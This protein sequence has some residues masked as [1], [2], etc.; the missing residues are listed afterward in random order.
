MR[1][2]K[3]GADDTVK[4]EEPPNQAGRSRRVR[5]RV[6]AAASQRSE[7]EAESSQLASLPSS[8]QDDAASS[9]SLTRALL[10]GLFDLGD[11]LTDERLVSSA[12]DDTAAWAEPQL[13]ASSGG[14]ERSLPSAAAAAAAAISTALRSSTV[15]VKLASH[16]HP[17]MAWTAAECAHAEQ[18][19]VLLPQLQ[20]PAALAHLFHITVAAIPRAEAWFAPQQ[21]GALAA[22]VR[23]GCTLITLHALL[24]AACEPLS[25]AELLDRVLATPGDGGAFLRAQDEVVVRAAG[26]GTEASYRRGAGL[27]GAAAKAVRAVD[28]APRL[29]PLAPLAVLCTAA[30][31]LALE[32]APSAG[33]VFHCRLATGRVLL[34]TFVA[35]DGGR[36]HVVLPRCNEAGVALLEAQPPGAPLHHLGAPRPVLLTSDAAIAAEVAAT[37]DALRVLHGTSDAMRTQVELAVTTLGAALSPSAT[38]AVQ[39]AAA[40]ASLIMGWRASLTCLLQSPA[41]TDD[42]A[43]AHARLLSLL[44]YA[45]ASTQ[46]NMMSVLM[47]AS[48]ML[49]RGGALAAALMREAL[50][51]GNTHSALAA[52]AALDTLNSRYSAEQLAEP[53]AAAAASLLRAIASAVDAEEA[54]V[55]YVSAFAKG[56]VATND[57]ASADFEHARLAIHGL[58]SSALYVGM[59]Y[60]FCFYT[61]FRTE[62]VSTGEVLA[63]LPCPSWSIWLRMPTAMCCSGLDGPVLGLRELIFVLFGSV[64][65]MPGPKAQRLRTLYALHVHTLLVFYNIVVDP[66]MCALFTH[67]LYGSGI[68]QP[69]QGGVKQILHTFLAHV[70]SAQQLPWRVHIVLFVFRGLLPLLVRAAQLQGAQASGTV[71]LVG[72]LR[73]LPAQVGWDWLHLAVC[74]ACVLHFYVVRSR[75]HLVPVKKGA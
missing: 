8:P 56:C 26:A 53:A 67:T 17:A 39:A 58:R 36:A 69:W 9:S 6:T 48:P 18:L 27:P 54:A 40:T 41:F 43:A 35:G 33:T 20:L 7:H 66:A 57:A 74:F 45:S 1:L 59:L 29:P 46:S 50:E 44:C 3:V 21:S 31:T 25:A 12:V 11:W 22:T 49:G 47:N 42:S 75:R 73:A 55:P 15:H 60:F 5:R 13:L 30:S 32:A 24:P 51:N 4:V 70:S 16:E 28:E 38:A 64:A 71:R 62:P 23:P 10:D 63:A 65:F 19:R 68:R 2:D 14:D 34:L 37:G 52:A 72:M 61:R